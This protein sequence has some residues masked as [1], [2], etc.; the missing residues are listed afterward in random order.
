MADTA[1]R[2]VG[3]MPRVRA[4][5]MIDGT[6]PGYAS[7]EEAAAAVPATPLA[8]ELEGADLRYSS[9]TTGRPKGVKV[10]LKREPLG[11]PNALLMLATALYRMNGD[12]V[13]LSPA[14][15]YHAAPLRFNPAVQRMGGTSIV[16]AVAKSRTSP[17]NSNTSATRSACT[18]PP[19]LG[20]RAVTW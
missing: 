12:T 4:R 7:F 15:L 3:E 20:W 16:T 8:D 17:P 11:A 10:E 6:I 2:L 9:G 18:R 1:T 19:D 13:Y 5:L 14:P